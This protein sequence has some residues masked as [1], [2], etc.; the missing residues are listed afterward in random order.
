MKPRKT[1]EIYGPKYRSQEPTGWDM[2]GPTY[3]LPLMEE[4]CMKFT[5]PSMISSRGETVQFDQ[6]RLAG[7]PLQNVSFS[8]IIIY[9]L[10]YDG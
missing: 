8:D 7:V 1:R 9:Q 4:P 3:P 10:L 5:G 6:G 2:H